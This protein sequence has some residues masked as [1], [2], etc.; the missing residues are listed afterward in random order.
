MAVI[1]GIGWK[2]RESDLRK[3]YNLWATRQIEGMYTLASLDQFREDL[4]DAAIRARLLPHA[5]RDA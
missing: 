4:K 2:R 1:D 5:S 3:L